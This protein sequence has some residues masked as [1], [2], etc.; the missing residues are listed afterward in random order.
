ME[1]CKLKFGVIILERN[2]RSEELKK[3]FG[4]VET[5]QTKLIGLT[6]AAFASA[7]TTGSIASV[8]DILAESD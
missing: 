1:G 5:W 8:G 6:V 4:L 3:R 2:S 7:F